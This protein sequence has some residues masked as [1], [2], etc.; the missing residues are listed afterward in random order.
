M[1]YSHFKLSIDILDTNKNYAN[2][3]ILVNPRDILAS[4]AL[5]FN[6]NSKVKCKLTLL[7]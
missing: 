4:I 3:N 1:Y 7:E 5:V 2:S 6:F